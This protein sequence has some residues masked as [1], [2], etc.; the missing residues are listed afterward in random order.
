MFVCLRQLPDSCPSVVDDKVLITLACIVLYSESV[1][2]FSCLFIQHTRTQTQT[3]L[4]PA[5][6]VRTFLSLFGGVEVEATVHLAE[7]K[8][9]ALLLIW[10]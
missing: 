6:V 7:W 4:Q 2:G 9:A 3:H 8:A 1:N 10:Q 5:P